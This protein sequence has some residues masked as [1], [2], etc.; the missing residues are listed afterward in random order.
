MRYIKLNENIA[1]AK[2]ILRKNGIAEDDED[3]LKIREI[4]GTAFSY[5]GILTRL[6]FVDN[7]TDMEELKSI[8]EVL[9]DSK[10]DL[11]KLN[12]MSYDQILDTFYDQMTSP[13]KEDYELIY[14]DNS[15]SFFR[16]YTY[17]GI[18]EIGSPAWC[19]K[20]KSYWDNYQ[21]KYPEQWV[22]IDNRYVKRVITP[23][24]SYLGGQY[25]NKG[26]TWIRFGIS[27]KHEPDDTIS[28]V[29]HNDNDDKCYATP[30]NH[31]FFGVFFTI[32]NL[33]NGHKKS[34]YQRFLGCDN[35]K[36]CVFKINGDRVWA[37]R[38]GV[39]PPKNT[40]LGDENYL[41]LSKSYSSVP[42][43]LRLREKSFPCLRIFNNNQK[44]MHLFSLGVDGYATKALNDYVQKPQNISYCGI[45][46]KL[47]L[48][49]VDKLKENEDFILQ[50]GKWLVF[51]WNKD[52][53]IAIDS[54]PSEYVLPVMD[55]V[56]NEYWTNHNSEREL[57]PMFYYI[58][59][60][61]LENSEVKLDT[62][63]SKEI[64]RRLSVENQTPV[65]PES[66]Q[67]EEK[68]GFIKRFLGFK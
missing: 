44:V 62:P 61:K 40:N 9:R 23:N 43:I 67:E 52:Y 39:Q 29:A 66:P 30:Q 4:V 19:L 55:L 33:S 54:E 65:E 11:G 20:T 35:I 60:E 64:L 58:D 16:V 50:V 13:S 68:P 8:F 59:K 36:D 12:K 1:L 26:K 6:R 22:A 41:F 24:N 31:T 7:V 18:L 21:A 3:Y 32:M 63:E 25:V 45:R 53:Y 48:T 49:T 37:D 27:I 46:L 2:S 15:Y 10:L 38:L 51:H 57:L 42:I 28:F 17:K 5:V 56:G 34:Y 47:G 14:K